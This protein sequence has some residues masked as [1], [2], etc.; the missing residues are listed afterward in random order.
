MRSGWIDIG[1]NTYYFNSNGA[2]CNGYASIDNEKY[3]FL[4]G[5][6][7]KGFQT[8]DNVLCYF[9]EDGKIKAGFYTYKNQSLYFDAD[10]R[11]ANGWFTV[12]NQKFYF[13]GG[14]KLTG[15]QNIG[16]A[17][18]YLNADGT[19]TTGWVAGADGK[20][21]KNQ[22]GAFVYGWQTI[23]KKLY[24]FDETSGILSVSTYIGRYTIDAN[25]VAVKAA[26]NAATLNA[27]LDYILSQTGKAIQPIFN[28]V[29]GNIA[30]RRIAREEWNTM[31]IYALNNKRGA[32]YHYSALLDLLLKRA[33]YETVPV[34]GTGHYT[35]EHWWNKVCVDGKWYNIDACNGYYLVSDSY[36]KS[37]NYTWNEGAIPASQ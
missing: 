14:V 26:V 22:Y 3:F 5:I 18:Y 2:M 8:I 33:G 36:L 6:L 9:G 29:R 34:E 30:Y 20:H 11:L 12:N 31:A 35:S 17:V 25:G 21:Y 13:S 23:D 10:G 4:D 28:Y 7:K 19:L 1:E 24:H 27:E 37:K 16:G 15:T 32:C